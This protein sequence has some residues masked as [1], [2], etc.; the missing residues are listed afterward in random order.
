VIS[1]L[2][3]SPERDSL[4]GFAAPVLVPFAGQKPFAD[5][6]LEQVSGFSDGYSIRF[7]EGQPD[8]PNE[9]Y[10]TVRAIRNVG[11]SSADPNYFTRCNP[12]AP[13]CAWSS[14]QERFLGLQVKQHPAIASHVTATVNGNPE[15]WAVDWQDPAA[16]VTY[17]LRFTGKL[18]TQFGT[19]VSPENLPAAQRL[20]AMADQ[21]VS[22]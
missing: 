21:L 8:S 15:G 11:V 14:G 7:G 13:Y 20:A 6:Q 18:A 1:V 3:A 2:Q 16:G 9:S 17:S 4:K 10:V 12:T 5:L 19:A 22:L